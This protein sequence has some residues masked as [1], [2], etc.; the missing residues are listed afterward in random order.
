MIVLKVAIVTLHRVFNYGS[1]LQTY[2]T[3]RVFS[4]NGYDVEI[5][6]YITSE[7]TFKKQFLMISPKV[8][9]SFIHRFIYLF[10]KLFSFFLKRLTLWYFLKKNVKLSKKKYVNFEDLKNGKFD[11]DIYVTGSDQVW[12]SK[13][14]GGIDRGFFLD[15]V[16]SSNKYSFS[17]SFGKDKL[18]KKE[19]MEISVL[20]NNYKL[21]SVREDTA[22]MLLDS[23]GI[24]NYDVIIDPTLQ[25]TK[26]E[27]LDIS[28]RRLFKKR[29]VLLFL[30]YNEDNGATMYA[31]QIADSLGISLVKL[32]WEIIKP[33]YVDKLFTHRNPN[34]F[35]SLVNNADFVVTN[36]FHG[37]AFSVNL[38]K[39]FIVVERTEFNSRIES[40]LRMLKLKDRLISKDFFDVSIVNKKIDYKI[41]DNILNCEREKA[42]KFIKKIGDTYEKD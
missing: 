1:V 10:L 18:D 30:L 6:D 40:L 7:R 36:S 22:G 26:D 42:K 31:R 20:L 17:S 9:K 32:S 41:I 23:M 8:K 11:A 38:Q 13:Y 12:N 25:L 21:L 16:E 15:F 2:A 5:I 14:N 19:K 27:W 4:N 3:Q 34:D 39:Q 29:Y 35:I 37:L 33:K 28:S 24:T